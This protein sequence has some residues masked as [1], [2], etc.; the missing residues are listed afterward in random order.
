MQ[1]VYGV[2]IKNEIG[3]IDGGIG[4][5]DAVFSLTLG[6]NLY[7]D[8]AHGKDQNSKL[9]LLSFDGFIKTPM[10]HF[11]LYSLTIGLWFQAF[12]SHS[13]TCFLMVAI[14]MYLSNR[15][16]RRSS[17]FIRLGRQGRLCTGVESRQEN[18]CP[19]KYECF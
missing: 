6:I 18:H 15:K 1:S 14:I 12:L 10:E 5:L 4:V 11:A 13:C 16:Q 8:S 3:L 19:G 9:E 2:L 7:L 17:V